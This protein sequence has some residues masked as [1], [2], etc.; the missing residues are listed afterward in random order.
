ML[1]KKQ[2]LTDTE[3]LKDLIIKGIQEKKGLDVITLDLRQIQNAVCDYFVIC[4]GS[5]TTQ[6]TALSD[7]VE[8]EVKKASGM[9]PSHKEG[10]TNAEWII[11]DYFDIVVHIFQESA[12]NFFQLEGLWA[13]AIIQKIE[14]IKPNKK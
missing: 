2:I 7:S 5:S 11:L 13:D 3:T 1:K 12:R 8:I 10:H 4:H 6:V 9:Y 14:D